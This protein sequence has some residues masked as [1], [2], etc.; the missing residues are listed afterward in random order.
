M[1]STSQIAPDKKRSMSLVGSYAE[2]HRRVPAPGGHALHRA[3]YGMDPSLS[4]GGRQASYESSFLRWRVV[5]LSIVPQRFR[6]REVRLCSALQTRSCE[7]SASTMA[8][9]GSSNAAAGK[10]KLTDEHMYDQLQARALAIKNKSIGGKIS[11]VLSKRPD[12]LPSVLQHIKDIGGTEV[13]R[14]L[15]DYDAS[16]KAEAEW[17]EAT[18]KKPRFKD[19]EDSDEDGEHAPPSSKA[20]QASVATQGTSGFVWGKG[21][22]NDLRDPLP[23]CYRAWQDVPAQYL[24]YFLSQAEPVSLSGHALK[25]LREGKQKSIPKWIILKLWEFVIAAEK[26]DDILPGWRSHDSLIKVVKDMN[27]RRGRLAKDMV[28]PL[29]YLELGVYKLNISSAAYSITH[30]PSNLTRPLPETFTQSCQDIKKCFIDKNGAIATP[31]SLTH[32]ASRSSSLPCCFQ[33]PRS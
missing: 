11:K 25:G 5:G 14:I 8:P 32:A 13:R 28:M 15:D 18:P 17:S 12:L 20:S 30:Q 29:D 1:E 4:S 9:K 27:N 16:Q 33:R 10:R 2:P 21:K 22:P 31:S 6:H 23:R 7:P 19:E 3:G 24:E 26:E